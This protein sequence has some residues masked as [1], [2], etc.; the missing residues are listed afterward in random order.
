[1]VRKCGLAQCCEGI[2]KLEGQ[3]MVH[4]MVV[5]REDSSSVLGSQTRRFG[6]RRFQGG[7]WGYW[8]V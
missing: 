3:E 4:V 7:R 8:C 6:G 2:P 5:L 1:M